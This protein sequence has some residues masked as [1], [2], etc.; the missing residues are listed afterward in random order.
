MLFRAA[1]D[2]AHGRFVVG[3]DRT[4]G[5]WELDNLFADDEGNA[6]AGDL[7]QAAPAQVYATYKE[8]RAPRTGVEALS[9]LDDGRLIAAADAE[10]SVR[11]WRLQG[12]GEVLYARRPVHLSRSELSAGFIYALAFSSDARRLAVGGSRYLSV[13]DVG[14]GSFARLPEGDEPC[15]SGSTRAIAGGGEDLWLAWAVQDRIRGDQLGGC[16]AQTDGVK[17]AVWLATEEGLGDAVRIPLPDSQGLWSIALSARHHLLAAG[18]FDGTVWLWPRDPANGSPRAENVSRLPTNNESPVRALAF[19]PLRPLL[20]FGTDSGTI[21]MWRLSVPRD[22]IVEAVSIDSHG[23]AGRGPVRA[24][25][26]S[27][28]GSSM[29]FGDDSGMLSLVPLDSSDGSGWSVSHATFAH[30]TGVTDLAFCDGVQSAS[31]DPKTVASVGNDGRARLWLIVGEGAEA[32]LEPQLTLEGPSVG[33]LSV[34]LSPDGQ[35]IAAG[36]IEG[37]VHV[38]PLDRRRVIEGGCTVVQ[39]NLSEQEWMR[40]VGTLPYECT[41]PKL[42]PG[43]R[44]KADQITPKSGCGTAEAFQQTARAPAA[45]RSATP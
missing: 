1:V 45:G 30:S 42:P 36:D 24:L 23:R 44:V 21:E 37:D 8:L 29:V 7:E 9:A 11:L 31:C 20:A 17:N 34:A 19:H 43:A 6:A 14:A 5:I 40:Y 15:V 27:P 16:Q 28:D 35:L 38:W 13:L 12:S 25:A 2:L 32:R 26:F 39:R 22:G 4:I 41:C 33:V 18:D 10:S 3:G